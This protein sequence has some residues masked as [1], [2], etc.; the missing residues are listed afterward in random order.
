[1]IRVS[2]TAGGSFFVRKIHGTEDCSHVKIEEILSCS[3]RK[4]DMDGLCHSA[5]AETPI[6]DRRTISPPVRM[7]K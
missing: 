5:Q 3:T 7:N 2:E 1:M 6:L 4:K